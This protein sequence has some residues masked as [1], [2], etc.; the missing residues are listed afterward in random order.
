[1]V[2]VQQVKGF[3]PGQV[4]YYWYCNIITGTRGRIVR[5]KTTGQPFI[6]K[7]RIGEFRVGCKHGLRDFLQLND[8]NAERFFLSL[9]DAKAA[10]P[11]AAIQE[12][13]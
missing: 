11:N 12:G 6:Y 1:M 5:V 9:D 8:M 7:R 3:K 13:L 4:L 10:Y 2:I